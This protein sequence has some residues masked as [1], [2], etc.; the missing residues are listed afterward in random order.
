MDCWKVPAAPSLQSGVVKQ[1]W[2]C[3]A[4]HTVSPFV[5]AAVDRASV[6]I[7]RQTVAAADRPLQYS[8]DD[9]AVARLSGLFCL[10]CCQIDRRDVISAYASLQHQKVV[11]EQLVGA[12]R[13]SQRGTETPRECE[14]RV[15]SCRRAFILGPRLLPWWS[16][17]SAKARRLLYQRPSDRQAASGGK[18]C[19]TSWCGVVVW[20][21]R[22]RTPNQKVSDSTPNRSPLSHN[23][24]FTHML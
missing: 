8:T 15:K 11:S 5:A 6:T 10:H 19:N 7:S 23:K 2:K 21:L 3:N 9:V 24:S 1:L 14:A 18:L 12:D 16:V 17:S 22:R 13:E 4:G 20:W